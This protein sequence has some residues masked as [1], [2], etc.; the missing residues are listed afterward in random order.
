MNEN[1]YPM[2]GIRPQIHNIVRLEMQIKKHFLY[3]DAIDEVKGNKVVLQKLRQMI[4]MVEKL[5]KNVENYR[6]T[7]NK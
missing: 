5:K 3:I 4:V 7:L 6:K 1:K 2:F